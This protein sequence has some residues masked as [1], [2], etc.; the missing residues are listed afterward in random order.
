M[1]ET[2]ERSRK[3]QLGYARR[4]AEQTSLYRVLYHYRDE[5]ERRWE[6]LF[7]EK[8]GALRH[9]VLEAV[10]AYLNCGILAHGCARTYCEK[11]HH[12]ELIAFS[13]PSTSA[14]P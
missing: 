6:E 11:C 14:G 10:D 3:K 8:Y 12:S 5:F 2:W 13:C 1:E 7:Q 4:R 9:E